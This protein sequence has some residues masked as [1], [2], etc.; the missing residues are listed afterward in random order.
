MAAFR[1]LEQAERDS[2]GRPALVRLRE[3]GDTRG[4]V[5]LREDDFLALLERAGG[6][7]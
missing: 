3:D 7:I 6:A 1:H 2:D 4:A 5:L